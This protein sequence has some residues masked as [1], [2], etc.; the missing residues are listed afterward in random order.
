MDRDIVGSDFNDIKPTQT[1]INP[2]KV[3]EYIK[4]L[5]AGEKLPPIEVIDI[6]GKGRY[7]VEGHHR[8]V[9]SQQMGIPIEI[10]V[11]EGAG[12]VGMPNW[13]DVQWRE[14]IDESQFWDD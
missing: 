1:A 13:E 9:A 4:R 7:I 6:P 3:Q 12:P 14:Y 10:I 2:E 8:Y 11:I 5:R